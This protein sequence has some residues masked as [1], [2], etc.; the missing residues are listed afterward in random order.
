[1]PR[2][3]TFSSTS[4]RP[5]RST[6]FPYT[7]LFRSPLL[8]GRNCT[9]HQSRG[10]GAVALPSPWVSP[11]V[12]SSLNDVNTTAEAHTS[13]PNTPPLTFSRQLTLYHPFSTAPGSITAESVVATVKS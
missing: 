9:P 2:D 3:P 1:M 10:A 5:P 13:A 6:L 7:T 12:V 4:R 11:P 8:P